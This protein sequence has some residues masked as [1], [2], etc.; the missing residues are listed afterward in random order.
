MRPQECGNLTDV[1]WIA[2][3]DNL[4]NGFV[5]AGLPVLSVSALNINTDDLNWSPKTRHACEVRKNNFITVH[6]DMLQM[7]V[8]GDNS[9]GAPI[10]TGYT[11]PAKEYSY[12]FRFKPF[13]VKEGTEDKIVKLMY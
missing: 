11:I 5:A 2:L 4:G 13:S 9:W 6:L 10:H 7:G 3:K 1:R 12:S 8:G